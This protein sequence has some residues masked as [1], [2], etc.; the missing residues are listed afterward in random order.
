MK[1]AERTA[2]LNEYREEQKAIARERDG[3]LCQ[4][5]YNMGGAVHHVYGR[6]AT[7]DPT[8]AKRH[9]FYERAE[10]L[11]TLC[12]E[13]HVR[14]HGQVVEGQEPIPTQEIEEIMQRVERDW[15]ERIHAKG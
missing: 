7:W 15:H 13:C 11:L 3:D 8:P 14:S 4:R 2:K 9:E 5:C 1:K 10:C 6:A 12:T